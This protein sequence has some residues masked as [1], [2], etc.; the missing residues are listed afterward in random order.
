[1]EKEQKSQNIH[2]VLARSYMMYFIF[3]VIGLWVD[4]YISIDFPF[5]LATYASYAL[6][7]IG[8]LLILWAQLSS[9]KFEKRKDV[10]KHFYYG[11]YA[12]LRNPTHLG[13]LLLVAGYTFVSGSVI[14]FATTLISYLLSSFFYKQHEEILHSTYGDVYY[15]YKK[16]VK[17]IL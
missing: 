8:P 13:L 16:K 14:F 17:K 15:D 2:I 10:K 3:S 6:F 7:I 11:P 12:F 5:K 9:R 4:S 1:M